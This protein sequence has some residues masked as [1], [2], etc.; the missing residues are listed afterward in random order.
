[1]A[2]GRHTLEI[3]AVANGVESDRSAG[4]AVMVVSAVSADA[5]TWPDPVSVGIP[6]AICLGGAGADCYIPSLVAAGLDNVTAFVPTTSDRAFFIEGERFVRVLQDGRLVEEP[7]LSMQGDEGR[8][9]SLAAAPDFERSRHV[10]VAWGTP[11]RAERQELSITRYRELQGA[12]GEGATI[13]TGL[14]IPPDGFAPVA[15]DDHGLLYVA[16]PS[17]EA[18]DLSEPTAFGTSILRFGPDGTVPRNNPQPS[19]VI[20]HGY[21][22]PSA[23]VWDGVT[24]Q[25]WLAGVDAGWSSPVAVLPTRLDRRLTWPWSPVAVLLHAG[26]GVAAAS[27]H[28]AIAGASALAESRQAWFVP[29]PGEVYRSPVLPDRGPLQLA[30][31][32]LEAIGN[33]HMVIGESDT[34]LIVVAKPER[35]TSRS[36]EIWRLERAEGSNV[37]FSR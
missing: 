23:L 16:L 9:V 11:T 10:Y 21:A 34:S 27:P 36:S 32:D 7:A 17:E 29:S 18:G 5:Q 4:L 2:E 30:R 14:P 25:L 37:R 3:T 26:P 12:L 31:V 15:I 35:S 33:V 20:A 22:R 8:L 28:F 6:E 24:H 1:M 19:P 13:A